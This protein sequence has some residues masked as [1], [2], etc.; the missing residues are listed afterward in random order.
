MSCG[1]GCR[2]GLDPRIALA[3]VRLAATAPIQPLDW[4]LPYAAR[5]GLK[6]QTIITMPFA[7]TWMQLKVLNSLSELSQ[8]EK[9][10]SEETQER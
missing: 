7:A 8:K 4:E 2:R 1:V 6:R 9:C 10:S 3:V 5:A